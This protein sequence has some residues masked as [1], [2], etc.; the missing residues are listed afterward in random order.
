[1]QA[2]KSVK[3]KGERQRG[4]LAKREIAKRTAQQQWLEGMHLKSVFVWLLCREVVGNV[5]TPSSPLSYSSFSMKLSASLSHRA[6]ELP[7]KSCGICSA[8][9]GSFMARGE[10]APVPSALGRKQGRRTLTKTELPRKQPSCPM[11]PSRFRQHL[12]CLR[13]KHRH[14]FPFLGPDPALGQPC[15]IELTQDPPSSSD[16]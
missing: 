16:S 9:G 11:K 10:G 15:A 13:T 1:M 7:P 12:W 14:P 5:Q 2:V 3:V 4:R 6:Q 8:F